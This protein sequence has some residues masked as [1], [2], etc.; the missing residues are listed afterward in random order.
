M[1]ISGTNS[2]IKT[3]VYRKEK[4]ELFLAL[5][6]ICLQQIF[7]LSL[8]QFTSKGIYCPQGNF[9]ID[10][11]K[12]VDYAVITHGHGDHAR[13]GMQHYLCQAFSKPVLQSRLGAAISLETLDYGETKMINGVR[14]SL[15]PAGHIIGS[16]QVRIE[17]NGYVSV[18]SGDYKTEHDGISTPLEVL[19]CNEF[20][21]ESTFGLPIYN[22]LSQKEI[23]EE[24]KNWIAL[25]QQHGKT[26]VFIAY[27]LGKAQRLMKG[28]EGMAKLYVHSSIMR[29]NEAIASA[30]IRLPACQTW[31]VEIP[32]NELQ[33]QIVILPPSLLGTNMI[34]KIPN[35]AVAICSGWMQVRGSRR[36]Q[37]VDAGFAISD[38]ADWNGLLNTVK[39][40]GAEKVF[41]T[42][43]YTA[44]FAKY[45]NEIGIEAA[46][47]QTQFGNDE[48][49]DTA[50]ERGAIRA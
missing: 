16:A 14:L 20:V 7:L 36:W 21:T 48:E 32:K 22:W 38:H 47:V 11:W 1:N 12:P 35:S 8:L 42:H 2:A 50:E 33:G 25:N 6:W 18:V 27:S 49:T 10:P 31:N 28:L 30:G 9:Y 41:V 19:H 40:T 3:T 44:T 46:E 13:Y 23:F 37:S 17:H 24:V 29:L 4:A 43:G 26:S 34:K 5:F 15:H 45:L 39:A